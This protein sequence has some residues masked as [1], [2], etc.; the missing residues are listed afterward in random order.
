MRYYL[1]LS[2]QYIKKNKARTLYSVFGIV[3]CFLL[4][5]IVLTGFYSWWEYNYRAGYNADPYELYTR[6]SSNEIY[7]AEKIRNVKLLE[8]DDAVENLVIYTPDSKM[9]NLK[10]RVLTSG[11]KSGEAYWLCLK[12]KNT[13]NLRSSAEKLSR[14][15][16]MNFLIRQDVAVY[17]RQD[18]S[19]KTALINVMITL[20][21][22]LFGGFSVIILR[23]TMMISVTERV[24]DYGLL[25]CV[26]MS[27]G[28]LCTILFMEGILM[29][30][31]ASCIGILTGYGGLKLLEPWF[32]DMMGLSGSF[33]FGFYP[34]A[35][36]ITTLLCVG[37]TLFALIEPSRQAGNVSPADALHGVYDSFSKRK[38]RVLSG[39]GIL[40]KIFGVA[41]FYAK[42]NIKNGRGRQGTVFFAMLFSV[43][44]LLTVLSFASTWEATTKKKIVEPETDYREGVARYSPS[45]V[46]VYSEQTEG[47]IRKSLEKLPDV[48]DTIGFMEVY[49]NLKKG[50]INHP[51]ARDPVLAKAALDHGIKLLYEFAFFQ[52]DM[53]KERQY[54]KE[55]EIDYDHMIEENGVL[56][57]DAKDDGGRYTDFR[58]GDTINVL[59]VAGAAKAKEVYMEAIC[60]VAERNDMIAYENEKYEYIRLENGK[61]IALS[62][63][64]AQEYYGLSKYVIVPQL[65][66]L[67][68]KDID[69]SEYERLK[70][71]M[72]AALLLRGYDC[73]D[74]LPLNSMYFRDFIEVLKDME[75]EKGAVEQYR[76]M[77]IL[78]DEIYSRGDI[79]DDQG[80]GCIRLIYPMET[81]IRRYE[82]IAEAEEKAG[83]A[84]PEDSGLYYFST[85][86]MMAYGETPSVRIGIRRDTE[87][88][89]DEIQ[90]FV[91]DNGRISAQYYFYTYLMNTDMDYYTYMRNVRKLRML[92]M[93]VVILGGFVITVCL[94]QIVNTL[95]AGMRMNRRELWL[96]EVVGMSRSQ[97]LR[98]QLIEHG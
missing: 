17:L 40:E 95:Q 47:E 52:E 55:G 6:Y 27:K 19:E 45:E 78:S 79:H 26:G 46:L 34:Q 90:R 37:E 39:G 71:E 35:A 49:G 81:L 68:K 44:F 29:S 1:H 83:A 61:E 65:C 91:G 94:V 75:Y 5:Y 7:D 30:L 59:S 8:K 58:P 36:V 54:L 69:E 16:N 88:L 9:P 51:A 2:S 53:E 25:R 38:K 24:R 62:M 76:I 93:A 28:Q 18:E 84:V 80:K 14:K 86:V 70:E 12:L 57:C 87:F 11:M 96:Y 77:G 74:R 73:R 97:K 66:Y 23:N 42:R 98:M 92:R 3:L 10:R 67:S 13:K 31:C 63:E 89:D 4:C 50:N 60:E 82:Q 20:M 15:Y 43:G 72:L 56:L 64:E 85:P 41:G 33:V 48:R 21:A 32:R 22:A